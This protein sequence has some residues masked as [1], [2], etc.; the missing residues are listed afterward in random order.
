MFEDMMY[1]VY[2][3]DVSGFQNLVNQS[4]YFVLDKVYQAV[5]EIIGKR[6]DNEHIQQMCQI[7]ESELDDYWQ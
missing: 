3:N 1:C 2:Q 7:L 6:E 5:L 4:S